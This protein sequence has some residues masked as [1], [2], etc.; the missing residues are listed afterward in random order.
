[1]KMFTNRKGVLSIILII[2]LLVGSIQLGFA[3]KA[4]AETSA[5]DGMKLLKST[6]EE[7]P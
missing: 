4:E 7:V 6:G 2:S 3:T 5:S 1:M